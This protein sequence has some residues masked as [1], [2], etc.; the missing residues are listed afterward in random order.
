MRIAI[1]SG[2]GG[3]G[4]TTVATNLAFVAAAA[5]RSVAYL[6]CDVEEPNGHIF[7]KPTIS[8]ETPITRPL[9][10]VDEK[11]CNG[12]GRCGKIC[13]Y[14]AI[15]CIGDRPLTFPKLCHS[16]GGCAMVCPVEAIKEVPR[17]IGMLRAGDSHGVQFVEGR[18][19]VGEAMSP[20]AIRAV[21]AAAPT[22]EL[23]IVDSPPGTSCPVIESVRGCDQVLLVTEPTPFGLHDLTLAVE[24]VSAMGLAMSVIINRADSGDHQTRQFCDRKGIAVLAEIPDVRAVAEAYSRGV[25]IAEVS[26][27]YRKGMERVLA[28]LCHRN[29]SPAP[30]ASGGGRA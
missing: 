10:Q 2:K 3:T 8:A 1:A 29:Q 28:R 15:V 13:Q 4:K 22:A 25:L 9:P 20:P 24:M 5:G 6:D 19:N 27:V 7:L 21:K 23:V 14:S 11:L 26:E 18:L 17:P 12:C 16:C 30:I